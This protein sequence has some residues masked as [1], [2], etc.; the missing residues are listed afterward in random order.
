[1]QILKQ[2]ESQRRQS[3]WTFWLSI[4]AAQL[5]G[6]LFATTVVERWDRAEFVTGY[7]LVLLAVTSLLLVKRGL[8]R[9]HAL[10]Q[11]GCLE[12]LWSAGIRA[13]QLVDEV[14]LSPVR[15]LPRVLPMLLLGWALLH[16]SRALSPALMLLV[17]VAIAAAAAVPAYFFT[18]A[19]RPAHYLPG[20]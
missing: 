16:G 11:G 3:D 4:S 2:L 18:G 20:L 6:C 10:R 1:M 5:A 17:S 14:A 19:S 12:E 8:D 15:E 9:L 7:S 13:S